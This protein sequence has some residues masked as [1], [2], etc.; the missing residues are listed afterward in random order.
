MGT[1]KGKNNSI[2]LQERDIDIL[3]GFFECRIMTALHISAIYFDGKKEATKKR[4]QKIKEAGF[5]RERPR[6]PFE[7]SV[8]FLTRKGLEVL[9]DRDILKEYPHFSLP[10]LQ[11]RAHVGDLTVRHELEVMNVKATFHSVIRE[12]KGFEIEEFSTWP[13]LNE[14]RTYRNNGRKDLVKPDGFIRIHEKEK[15]RGF[16]EHT[17]FLEVDLSNEAQN[18][19]FEKGV[20]YVNYFKTGGFAERHGR[21]RKEYR[22]FPFRVL[23]VLKSDERRNN[24]AERLLE[25]T[26]PILAQV[27]ISTLKEV[28]TDPLGEIWMRPIDYLKAM[29]GAGFK[30]V[31]SAGR[32]YRRQTERDLHIAKTAKKHRLLV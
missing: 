20:S 21:P 30:R 29:Q 24:L 23:M 12:T 16:L 32:H 18:I 5:I 7:P 1:S 31:K 17:F 4:L 3:R 9:R 15:D 27:Y 10:Q 19:L 13:L 25:N 28:E 6:K 11:R 22:N 14:F 8:L 2:H 26:P